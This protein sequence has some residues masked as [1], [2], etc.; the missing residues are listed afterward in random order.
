LGASNGGKIL[1]MLPK[2]MSRRE[3]ALIR[4]KVRRHKD[5][6]E[7]GKALVVDN[8]AFGFNLA[9]KLVKQLG[10]VPRVHA[11]ILGRIVFDDE[12]LDRDRQEKEQVK[13]PK[14]FHEKTKDEFRKRPGLPK[15]KTT[16]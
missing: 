3:K 7:Y 1:I 5:V 4:E 14:H 11:N 8:D 16:P 2:K 15:S 6:A 12:L 9:M 13:V 10:G